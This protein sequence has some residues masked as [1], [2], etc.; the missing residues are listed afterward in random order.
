MVRGH[1]ILERT[2]TPNRRFANLGSGFRDVA[3]HRQTC[4][5]LAF[6]TGAKLKELHAPRRARRLQTRRQSGCCLGWLND[7][8]SC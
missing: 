7:A 6:S 3:T 5:H 1:L 2:S 8:A 4:L